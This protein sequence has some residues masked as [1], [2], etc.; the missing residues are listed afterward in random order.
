MHSI[1]FNH[2]KITFYT[3]K[4]LLHKMRIAFQHE[5]TYIYRLREN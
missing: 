5:T 4:P 2:P 1:I 3:T